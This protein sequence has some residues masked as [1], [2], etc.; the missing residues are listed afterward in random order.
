MAEL[1]FS[2]IVSFQ[3][4][5][6]CSHEEKQVIQLYV[7]LY[8]VHYMYIENTVKILNICHEWVRCIYGV[9]KSSSGSKGWWFK[10]HLHHLFLSMH[11]DNIRGKYTSVYGNVY[12]KIPIGTKCGKISHRSMGTCVKKFLEITSTEFP[13]ESSFEKLFILWN[14]NG[15]SN[16]F[17]NNTLGINTGCLTLCRANLEDVVSV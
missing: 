10:S 12:V 11:P 13:G 14:C 4:N 6:G 9:K 8:T 7:H 1:I 15:I 2:V 3:Q 16:R 5:C 17:F